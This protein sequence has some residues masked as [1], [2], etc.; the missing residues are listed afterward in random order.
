M[1]KLVFNLKDIFSSTTSTGCLSQYECTKYHIP[2]YQR[3]YKWSSDANGAVSVLLND[4]YSAFQSKPDKEYYLQ[5]ITVKR[6]KVNGN[7]CLEVIDGQQRLTTLSILFSVLSLV[8]TENTSNIAIDKLDYAVRD[9][10]FGKHI[11]P[12]DK[13]KYLIEANWDRKS[14][15]E[16]SDGKK[17]NFQDIYYLTEAAKCIYQFLGKVKKDIELFNNFLSSEV[18]IIVNSVEKHVKSETVFNNLNSNKVALTETDLIKAL[19]I[20]R[21]GRTNK[22]EKAKHFRE[23]SE[24]RVHLGRHWDEISRWVK[25]PDVNSFYFKGQDGMLGLLSL[26]AKQIKVESSGKYDKGKGQFPLF[27]FFLKLDKSDKVYETA[28]AVYMTLKDWYD[29]DEF[30]NLIGYCRF[31]KGSKFSNQAF[32]TECLEKKNK[33]S[34]RI[35]LN[36][37]KQE[38]LKLGDTGVEGLDYRQNPHEIQ[39][40]LLAINIF[41]ENRAEHRFDFYEFNKKAWSLE[42]IFPQSPEGKGYILKQNEK[43]EIVDF[44]GGEESISPETKALILKPER[45]QE[46]KDKYYEK[47]KGTKQIDNIGNMCLLT[48]TDNT[49]IGCMFFAGKRDKIIQLMREGSFVPRHTYEVFSKLVIENPQNMQVWTTKNIDEHRKYIKTQ[50]ENLNPIKEA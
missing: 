10:F 1:K 23:I 42:H 19:L 50:F 3:G 5:Y 9:D 40:L 37:T 25:R 27:N 17:H 26:T 39:R 43:D 36:E 4:L 8:R 24:T 41:G 14:G 18:K 34:V 21:I 22:G 11:Y 44:L 45:T 13:L 12:Q 49:K 28:R 48:G 15:I 7:Y 20:T 33:S 2:A 32:L 46:E 38:L 16:L 29:N 47:L 6:V 35:L 30:Y 31:A